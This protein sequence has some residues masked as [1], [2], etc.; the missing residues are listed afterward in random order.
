MTPEQERWESK[1]DK[2]LTV[3]DWTPDGKFLII[4][5]RPIGTGEQRL[6]LLPIAGTES[7]E[8][9]L[10]VNGAN[11]DSGMISPDGRW[12]AYR[13]DESGRSEIYITSFPKPTG[14]LQ[15]SVA[16]GVNPR[17]RHAGEE[18]YYLAPDKELMVA[19]LK[20]AGGSL[21]VASTRPLFEMFPT[22]FMTATG[23]SQYDVAQDGS[24]FVV[25]SVVTDESPTPLNLVVNWDAELKKK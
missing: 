1:D 24:R 13:S 21:Q 3:A 10:E 11:V 23:M 20:E 22:M 12:I 16:G 2:Y 14:K 4:N 15:V 17:W 25:D 7:G 9:L 8:P 19:E 5:E 18:L 6:L